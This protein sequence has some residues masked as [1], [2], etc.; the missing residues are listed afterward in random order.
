MYNTSV[1][2]DPAAKH[3]KSVRRIDPS[4]GKWVTV[5]MFPTSTTPNKIIRHAMSGSFQNNNGRACRVGTRDEDLFFSVMFATGELGQ[6]GDVLFYDSPEQYEQHLF[7]SLSQE[8][9]ANWRA[10]RDNALR[11]ISRKHNGYNVVVK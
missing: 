9:K 3:R 1:Y 5:Y 6:T 10:K 8:T 11:E 7:G 2:T 4:T